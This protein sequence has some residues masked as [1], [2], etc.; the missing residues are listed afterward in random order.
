MK[1]LIMMAG[2]P[3]SGKST[4]RKSLVTQFGYPVVC[5]DEIRL[6]L[7]NT[8]FDADR[9]SEVW[10]IVRVMVQELF[11]T[12]S[13]TVIL[14]ATNTTIKRRDEWKSDQWSRRIYYMDTPKNICIDR[15]KDS[16]TEYLIPVIERMSSSLEVPNKTELVENESLYTVTESRISLPT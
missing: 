15:A 4:F 7:H 14:D 1:N 13:S 16:Q 8:S 12:G 10:K 9:E 6:L 5:P 3:R 11:N 2:L